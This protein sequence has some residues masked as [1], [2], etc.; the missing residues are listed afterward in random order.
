MMGVVY[1]A[2]YLRYFEAG[3]NELLRDVGLCYR[4]LELAGYSLPV[5]AVSAKYRAPAR[6]DDALVLETSIAEIGFASIRMSYRLLRGTGGELL[7][8]GE[9]THACIGPEGRICRLPR[10]ILDKIGAD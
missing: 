1:Y 8:T 6:Y 10:Q 7:A 2:N 3:R 5:T 9:T 4:D